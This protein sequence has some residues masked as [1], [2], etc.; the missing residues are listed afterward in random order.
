MLAARF[1]RRLAAS[2][3]SAATAVAGEKKKESG[4]DVVYNSD[5]VVVLRGESKSFS[6]E[7]IK[8]ER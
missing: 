6:K 4:Q 8:N 1:L 2:F 7:E 5:E 3:I